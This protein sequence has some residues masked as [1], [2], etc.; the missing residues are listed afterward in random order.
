MIWI[1]RRNE[2]AQLLQ[3]KS[4]W[5]VDPANEQDWS[6]RGQHAEFQKHERKL[7][8]ELLEL[9]DILGSTRSAIVQ[10]VK[11]RRILLARKTIPCGRRL[12]RAQVIEEVAHLTRL[13]HAHILR[14][15]GTYVVGK[16]LSILLYPVAEYN[17]DDFLSCFWNATPTQHEWASM[18]RS[19]SRFYGCLSS[20]LAH[21]H[22]CLTKH[23]DIKPQ[24]ILV[25]KTS[26]HST[27]FGYNV[28]IADFGIAK[29]YDRQE[30]IETD[31]A[32]AFT[33]KYA[34]PEVVEQ[35]PRGLPA[36]IFSLGC[37]FLEIYT[38]T[39][40][41]DSE[42]HGSLGSRY[43]EIC[44]RRRVDARQSSLQRLQQQLEQDS[45]NG[46]SYQAHI[47][48]MVDHLNSLK[49]R[50]P[51]EFSCGFYRSDPRTRISLMISEEPSDRLTIGELVSFFGTSHCC[52]GPTPPLEAFVP[53]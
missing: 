49:Y 40:D 37:V 4:L 30:A 45:C 32:T 47:G 15:I 29:S 1:F 10:S 21:I 26:S 46:A 39:T 38:V 31:G 9:H 12:T 5:P 42:V 53:V 19:I 36:D 2:Y 43:D 24:N 33:L 22:G 52:N 28:Y 48:A 34:A 18:S 3:A 41:I 20:A 51:S 14:V 11:C 16:E 13:N 44:E 6:G 27:F 50:P 8:N 23:M 7:I 25:R 17:L 35:G